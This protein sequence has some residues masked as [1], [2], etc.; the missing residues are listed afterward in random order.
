MKKMQ[1]A[2]GKPSR[3]ALAN[4]KQI[5]P[6][7][8]RSGNEYD[9][10]IVG[11]GPAG[12]SAA[13]ILGRCTRRVLICDD[14]TPRS[15]AAHH[16]HGFLT[17]DGEGQ[18]DFRAIGRQQ[19]RRYRN[20]EFRTAQVGEVHSK[21][22]RFVVR[23]AGAV[24]IRTR[25]VL[26]ATG[27]FDNLP[28]I[29]GIESYFGKTALPCPYCDGWEMRGKAITVYGKGGR[30]FEMARAMTAWSPNLT[31]CTGGPSGLNAHQ[32]KLLKANGIKVL[33]DRVARLV[34]SNGQLSRI[35]FKGGTSVPTEALFF[36]TPCRQ[37]SSL[38]ERTGCRLMRDGR[39]ACDES[40]ATSV[41]G[42][43]AAGN[44]LK[45]VQ[46]SIVAAGDGARAALA[47]NRELTREDFANRASG[48]AQSRNQPE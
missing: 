4:A 36:D 39:V 46:L 27:V 35:V 37:Q 29:P 12:L 11:A 44:I 23:I 21:A 17:R 30:G 47:I 6:A 3:L 13:L 5:R 9:V 31:L 32:L 43:F 14:G 41:A 45:G 8:R 10:V 38:A 26:L 2:T 34:G 20:V 22:R 24:A 19:L 33:A 25:K 1:P 28:A 42:I 48:R 16:V 7:P 18:D 15:W 40:T